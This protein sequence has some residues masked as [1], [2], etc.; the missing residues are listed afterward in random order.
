MVRW[1]FN[2]AQS[3]STALDTHFAYVQKAL[4]NFLK[5]RGASIGD[6]SHIEHALRK[7]PI[8][9]TA[10]LRVE[11]GESVEELQTRP[12]ASGWTRPQNMH[13]LEF[14]EGGCVLRVASGFDE[15]AV[16]VNRVC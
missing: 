4:N 11:L 12:P 8:A 10:T 6:P 1:V 2:E 3:G 9:G 13:E 5:K 14:V 15:E 16:G 7:H